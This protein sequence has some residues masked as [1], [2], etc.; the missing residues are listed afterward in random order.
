MRL[1]TFSNKIGK[2]RESAADEVG[3]L[4]C[5]SLPGGRLELSKALSIK[6]VELVGSFVYSDPP[7]SQLTPAP[8][9]PSFAT[10]SSQNVYSFLSFSPSDLCQIFGVQLKP[11]SLM[12]ERAVR[13]FLTNFPSSGLGHHE[14]IRET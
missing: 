10:L 6:H 3:A 2:C 8:T 13:A 9:W 5:A 12:E 1:P 14:L 11:D 4:L 7:F